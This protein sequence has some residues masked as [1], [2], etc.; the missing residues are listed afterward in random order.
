MADDISSDAVN[1][2]IDKLITPVNK[3]PIR[4]NTSW[5]QS[6]AAKRLG[7]CL[8]CV[9]PPSPSVLYMSKWVLRF[10]VCSIKSDTVSMTTNAAITEVTIATYNVKIVS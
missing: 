6:M 2:F 9:F 5:L 8:C 10:V 1:V 3:F 7:C 4:K